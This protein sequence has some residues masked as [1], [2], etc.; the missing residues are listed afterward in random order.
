MKKISL[1]KCFANVIHK[2][3][4]LQK[5]NT[6]SARQEYYEA[7]HDLAVARNKKK[8]IPK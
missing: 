1:L 5:S 3:E 6:G 2:S 4:R 7:L 8:E